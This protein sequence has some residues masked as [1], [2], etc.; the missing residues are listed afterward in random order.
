[1]LGIKHELL[2]IKTHGKNNKIYT[3][4]NDRIS[5]NDSRSQYLVN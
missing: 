1:M 5:M 3:K 4:G 2:N